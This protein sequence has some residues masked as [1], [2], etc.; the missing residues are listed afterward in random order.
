MISQLQNLCHDRG[1]LLD[2]RK[3]W[4]KKETFNDFMYLEI[5]S[6]KLVLN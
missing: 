3:F 5:E 6:A 2:L 4:K 1:N